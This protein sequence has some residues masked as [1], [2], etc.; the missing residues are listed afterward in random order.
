MLVSGFEA[1]GRDIMPLPALL[2][3]L[4][5]GAACGLL[6]AWHARRVGSIPSSTCR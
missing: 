2:G 3:L 6:Y 4:A 1:I 5:A